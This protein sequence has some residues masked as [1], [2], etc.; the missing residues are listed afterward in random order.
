MQTPGI[1]SAAAD[2]RRHR[3]RSVLLNVGVDA[4]VDESR[5]AVLVMV[6]APDHIH[7]V[8]ERRFADLAALSISVNI[9]HFLDGT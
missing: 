8:T 3:K 4:V 1:F 6:A 5:R 7:H 9:Q 2:A